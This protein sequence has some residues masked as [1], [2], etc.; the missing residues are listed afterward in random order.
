MLRSF[1]FAPSSVLLSLFACPFTGEPCF[2]TD[3][4]LATRGCEEQPTAPTACRIHWLTC[5]TIVSVYVAV[6]YIYVIV[7]VLLVLTVRLYNVSVTEIKETVFVI[8]A[9]I[10]LF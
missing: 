9:S 10:Y 6:F 5:F 7:I 4:A 2:H 8:F 1:H 3:A